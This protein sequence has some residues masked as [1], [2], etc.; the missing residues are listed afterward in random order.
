MF[1]CFCLCT[2][3]VTSLQDRGLEIQL[4]CASTCSCACEAHGI[5]SCAILAMCELPDCP[6]AGACLVSDNKNCSTCYSWFR[7]I[8]RTT[9]WKVL[10]VKIV[11]DGKLNVYKVCLMIF[12]HQAH[13]M[14]NSMV[15]FIGHCLCLLPFLSLYQFHEKEIPCLQTY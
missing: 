6:K 10:S 5:K 2:V 9:F 1:H 12:V 13:F 11:E 8:N 4:L 3:A 7:N 14:N 15:V